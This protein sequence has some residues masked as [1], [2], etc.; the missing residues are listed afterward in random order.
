MGGSG[1]L[2]AATERPELRAAIALTPWANAP[3]RR[4]LGAPALI[5]AAGHDRTAPPDRHA[6]PIFDALPATLP[7]MYVELAGASHY[8]PLVRPTPGDRRGG[9]RLA[10]PLP[11]G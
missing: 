1:A 11:H 5:V 2:L 10:R 9:H 8:A 6:R 4:P 3:L 7:R